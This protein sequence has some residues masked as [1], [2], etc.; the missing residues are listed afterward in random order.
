MIWDTDICIC[1]DLQI[2]GGRIQPSGREHRAGKKTLLGT[3]LVAR[4]S[5]I[6]R[7][8]SCYTPL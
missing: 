5:A 1:C 8:Y 6:V 7:Y 2:T 4:Y 3:L